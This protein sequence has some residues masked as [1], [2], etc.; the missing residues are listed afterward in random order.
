[1]ASKKSASPSPDASAAVEDPTREAIFECIQ[2]AFSDSGLTPITSPL[3]NINW[4]TIPD[5]VKIAIA[6]FLRKCVKKKLRDPGDLVGP[7]LV[8]SDQRPV[9]PVSVLIDIVVRLLSRSA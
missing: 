3:N 8:A 4:P 9:M 1:M 2:A 6:Q 7:I 5:E